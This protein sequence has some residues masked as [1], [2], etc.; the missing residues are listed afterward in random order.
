MVV[1]ASSLPIKNVEYISHKAAR[2]SQAKLLRR[3]KSLVVSQNI[4]EV[5]TK[6]E[7]LLIE[8]HIIQ[9][10]SWKVMKLLEEYHE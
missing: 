10:D 5:S 1:S 2:E 3:L 8:S 6:S 4:P 9:A 7:I